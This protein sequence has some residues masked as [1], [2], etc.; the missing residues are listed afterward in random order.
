[1]SSG[2]VRL[3]GQS[4]AVAG[5]ETTGYLEVTTEVALT[6]SPGAS[7]GVNTRGYTGLLIVGSIS[8]AQTF[9]LS[10]YV[11]LGGVWGLA[12]DATGTAIEFAGLTGGAISINTSGADRIYVRAHT[13]SGGTVEL[14]YRAYGP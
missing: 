10:I 6:D 1:M 8:A 13:I 12:L 2:R 7:A 9:S 3:Q 5:S 11:Q 4:Q 14:V